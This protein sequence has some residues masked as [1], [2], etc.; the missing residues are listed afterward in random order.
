MTTSALTAQIIRDQFCQKY[1]ELLVISDEWIQE[2]LILPGECIREGEDLLDT[3]FDNSIFYILLDHFYD[4]DFAEYEA[5]LYLSIEDS[6]DEDKAYEEFHENYLE[7]M[8]FLFEI[9]LPDT[10]R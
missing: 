3:E 2:N 10:C 1:R 7:R 8:D 6:N 4:A 9:G 5:D